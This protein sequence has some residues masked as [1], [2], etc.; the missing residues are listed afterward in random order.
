MKNWLS[1]P[2]APHRRAVP[3]VM[4]CLFSLSIIF[5]AGIGYGDIMDEKQILIVSYSRTG[6]SQSVSDTLAKHLNADAIRLIDKKDRS[7]FWGYITAAV[8]GKLN[9]FTTTEPDRIDL[10]RYS[11]IILISP[12]W[13]FKLSVATRTFIH[14]HQLEGK[15]VLLFTT[16]NADISGYEK[17]D[18]QASFIKRT[19]RDYM[20]KK[21]AQLKTVI[22]ETGAR[23]MGHYHITTRNATT[24]SIEEETNNF[25]CRGRQE[26]SWQIKMPQ[27]CS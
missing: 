23:F 1:L 11:E 16:A 5:G 21:R 19:L 24:E 17:Y 7:G 3:F 2:T 8:D 6:K 12:I 27:D 25:L 15:K 14:N 20:K 18:D 10:S 13:G 9:N 22:T 4:V 26:L